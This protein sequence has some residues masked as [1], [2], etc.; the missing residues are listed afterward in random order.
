MEQPIEERAD[1]GGIAEEFAP[2][3]DWTVRLSLS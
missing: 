3:L 1:G 2:V